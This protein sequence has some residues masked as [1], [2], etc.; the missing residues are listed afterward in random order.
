MRGECGG[1]TRN[2]ARYVP[3][4]TG[5]ARQLAQTLRQFRPT[6][7][8]AWHPS[9]STGRRTGDGTNTLPVRNGRTGRCTPSRRR[10]AGC[11]GHTC[12]R[13][14]TSRGHLHARRYVSM[15]EMGR[16]ELPTFRTRTGRATD[17]LHLD[18]SRGAGFEPARWGSVL[19]SRR[20]AST[21]HGGL[22]AAHHRPQLATACHAS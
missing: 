3:L 7:S 6:A 1:R 19:P 10:S 9:R 13:S 17:A 14:H 11:N 15:V 18:G 12:R 16:I 5:R 4:Q 20:G 22:R 8:P 2:T 21:L